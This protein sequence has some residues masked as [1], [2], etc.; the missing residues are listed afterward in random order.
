MFKEDFNLFDQPAQFPVFETN[1]QDSDD[2]LES[3]LLSKIDPHSAKAVLRYAQQNPE[4]TEQLVSLIEKFDTQQMNVFKLSQSRIKSW[5]DYCDGKLCGRMFHDS[6][7]DRSILLYPESKAM[8]EGK[9]FEYW[10][11]GAMD[12]H[13]NRPDESVFRL[14]KGGLNAAGQTAVKQVENLRLWIAANRIENLKINQ[15]FRYED[16]GAVIN[17]HPDIVCTID[18]RSVVIDLKWSDPDCTFGDFAWADEKL[19][20]NQKLLLQ[21]VHTQYI[22]WKLYDIEVDFVFYIV[23]HSDSANVKA[24]RIVH[25]NFKESMQRHARLIQ[26]TYKTIGMFLI[27]NAFAPNPELKRCTD[28]NVANCADKVYSAPIKDIII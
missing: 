17:V 7:F 3:F 27:L 19:P 4:S 10:A 24:R 12:Y 25:R 26:S 15:T 11:T 28:C 18:G 6:L 14:V 1:I 9:V 22:F 8:L 23:D 5:F 2:D 20:Y 16:Q 21:A 13:G